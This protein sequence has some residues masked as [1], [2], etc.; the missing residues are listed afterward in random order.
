V[1]LELDERLCVVNR[2]LDKL[3]RLGDRHV[4]LEDPQAVVD[5]A[6]RRVLLPVHHH[7]VRQPRNHRVA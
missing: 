4:T 6:Q 2:A 1:P 3:D 5:D 7:N